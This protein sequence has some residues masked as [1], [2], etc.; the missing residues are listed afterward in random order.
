MSMSPARQPFHIF[1]KDAI[2]L[3][4]VADLAAL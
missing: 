2:H 1:R 3:W 4:P